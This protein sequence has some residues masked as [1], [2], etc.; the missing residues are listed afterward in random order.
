MTT[1]KTTKDSINNSL[2]HLEEIVTWFNDQEAIDVEEG[3]E[4]VRQ[5][6]TLIKELKERIK[7]VENEFTDIKRSLEDAE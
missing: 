3:I 1:K 5:G 2:A 6:A 7:R 4:K